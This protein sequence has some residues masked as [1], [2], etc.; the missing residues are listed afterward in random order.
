MVHNVTTALHALHQALVAARNFS[1]EHR[2]DAVADIVDS[3][4]SIPIWIADPQLDRTE[5]IIRILDGLAAQYAE[6][7]IA[8]QTAA[9]LRN[10]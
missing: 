5:E 4:E 8:A 2:H 7:G 1:L 10:P 9:R 6:C 3:I